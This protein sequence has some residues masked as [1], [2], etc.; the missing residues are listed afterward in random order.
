M[1]NP[2]DRN[3]LLT[4]I[5]RNH[6]VE[7]ATIHVLSTRYPHTPIAGRADGNGYLIL[8][9]LPT[10]AVAECAREAASRLRSGEGHL[11]IHPNCGT[12]F[13]T[14]AVLAGAASYL[15]LLGGRS[16]RWQDRLERLPL[17]IFSTVFALI[18]AQPLGAAAQRHLTT[19]SEIGQLE[20]MDV[21]RIR[22]GRTFVHRVLT[23]G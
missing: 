16:S 14:A 3:P 4:R 19:S 22:G 11:A 9:S 17:A 7:H 12:S 10:Q 5:R 21:Q 18:V 2:L 23:Q 13:L 6:A 1:P 20:I 15:S 8:G